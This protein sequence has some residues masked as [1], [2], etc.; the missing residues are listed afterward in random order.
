MDATNATMN[1]IEERIFR[2]FLEKWTPKPN[3]R[4]SVDEDR[5]RLKEAFEALLHEYS[6]VQQSERYNVTTGMSEDFN[7]S[8]RIIQKDT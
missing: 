7:V 5:L 1:E 6:D 8:Y 3:E 2:G 4:S